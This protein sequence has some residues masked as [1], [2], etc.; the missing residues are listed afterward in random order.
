[1]FI[2]LTDHLRCPEDHEE[3][4]L[5]L[6]PD[7]MEGRSVRTGQLGCPICGRT[8]AIHDGIVELGAAPEPAASES[9]L[10]A[11]GLTALA[12][13]HGPG[14]YF[15][16]VGTLGSLAQEMLDVNPGVSLIAVNPPAEVVDVPGVSVIHSTRIPLKTRSMRGVALG[17]PY[18]DDPYWV[19]EA[20]RVVLL[21]L[22]IVGEGADPPAD[23]IE[24]MASAEQVWV[25]VIKR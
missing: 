25:G 22:R 12:G 8:F 14:G 24:L 1:M 17:R 18:A 7:E 6:L 13:L 15:A 20:A 5:V 9:R 4:F 19:G 10:D 2:E 16:L 3:G 21:G 11:E 23:L